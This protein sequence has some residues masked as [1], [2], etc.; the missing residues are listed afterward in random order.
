MFIVFVEQI[1]LVQEI[2]KAL[3]K[4]NKIKM[5]MK[6]IFHCNY[7]HEQNSSK[8]GII[9]ILNSYVYFKF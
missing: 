4:I 6:R 7:F 9:K 5:K 8:R 1:N 2:I 3:I